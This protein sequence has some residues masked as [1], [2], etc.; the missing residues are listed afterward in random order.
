[1]LLISCGLPGSGKS[2]LATK[3]SKRF[4]AALLRSDVVRGSLLREPSYTKREKFLVYEE[5][6]ERA[7]KLLDKG[8][9]VL[10]A[11]FYRASLREK[12]RELAARKNV[13][14]FIAEKLAKESD[15]R[16][17]MK[18]RGGKDRFRSDA[19]FAVYRKVRDEFEPLEEGHFT[20]EFADGA[21]FE[22][23]AD[24]IRLEDVKY[25]LT[26]KEAYAGKTGKIEMRETHISVVFL[27]G[28]HAY[29]VK[30]PIKPAF[31]DYSTLAKRRHFCLEEV[32]VNSMLSPQL[33]LGVAAIRE[34]RGRLRIGGK[35]R[36]VEYAVKMRQFPEKRMMTRLLPEGRVSE[37]IVRN[38]AGQVASFHKKAGCCNALKY[39][40]PEAVWK[41]FS[42][43]FLVRDAVG[44]K[45]DVIEKAA[46]GF[47][48]RERKLFLRR[49]KG[50]RIRE[51]HG[52]LHSGNVFIE[53]GRPYIFDA[54]EFSRA[55]SCCDVAAEV[56]FMAMDLEFHR[57]KGLADAFVS[58]YC[59]ITRDYE[60]LKL[61]GFYKCYRASIR[62][63]AHAMEGGTAGM[64]TAKRYAAKAVEYT[65]E[66]RQA[67]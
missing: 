44:K 41:A 49:V 57:R 46:K 24:S 11:T 22:K 67:V 4:G 5:M 51:C 50:K 30:R 33:Y 65:K 40:T 34:I 25:W 39:G 18:K 60:I 28:R 58:E 6:L 29:K 52:D 63:M 12:A 38:I 14:F 53:K 61:L 16:K 17:R 62:M 45:A 21:D 23:L 48:K 15:V 9:V 43:A 26:K 27:N 55:I 19:D 13:P 54:I 1:M 64:R 7:G 3:L 2:Y 59:R 31:L 42:N 47:L 10:D 66:F 20:I 56:A 32:R 35:G 8:S 36:V 37:K